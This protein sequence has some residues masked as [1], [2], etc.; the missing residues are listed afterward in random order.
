MRPAPRRAGGEV[1]VEHGSVAT[2]RA[3]PPRVADLLGL[4]RAAR[5]VGPY[6]GRGA[7]RTRGRPGLE[8][9]LSD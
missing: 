2:S 8:S 4:A 7:E 3:A 9:G 6:S 1:S 5:R